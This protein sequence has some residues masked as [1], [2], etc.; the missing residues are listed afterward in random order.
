VAFLSG[1]VLLALLWLS[2]RK[3]KIIRIVSAGFLIFLTAAAAGFVLL[4]TTEGSGAYRFMTNK[5]GEAT[6]YA[7]IA[8]WNV[9]RQGF[10]E[11]PILG[12][13]PENF[14]L[15]FAKYYNPCSEP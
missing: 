9:A 14:D 2:T 10:L 11:R 15:V 13:G 4:S 12:W 3:N 1:N 8:V 5:F 6:I 7:R